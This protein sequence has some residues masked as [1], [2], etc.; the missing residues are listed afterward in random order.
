MDLSNRRYLKTALDV[1]TSTQLILG[2]FALIICLLIPSTFLPGF[3]PLILQSVK[4]ILAIIGFNLVVCTLRKLKTLRRSTLVIHFGSIVILTGGLV[5]TFGFVATV[6]IYE[7]SSADTVYRWDIKQDVQLDF[8]VRI[9][10]INMDYY[11]VPVK[12]GVLKNGAK[13]DLVVTTTENSFVFEQYRVRVLNLDPVAEVVQLS[14]ETLPGEQLGTLF[15]SGQKNVPP[16]F[17]LEFKLVA[18]QKPYVKRMWVELEL[19]QNGQVLAEGTSEVNNPL[20][21]QGIQFFLTQLSTDEAGRPYAG[22]QI[23]KD[24]GLPY[25]YTGFFILFLGLLLALKRWAK[26][27]RQPSGVS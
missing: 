22:I 15:T 1:I 19:V 25:V 5:S 3:A 7:G 18:F 20:K 10:A 14:V 21:W 26:M 12:V 9:S 27:S 16:D 8:A 4:I 6:N 24:P 23:S 13:A 2:L 11:P 17:P